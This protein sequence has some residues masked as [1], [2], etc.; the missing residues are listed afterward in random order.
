MAIISPVGIYL[1]KRTSPKAPLPIILIGA[2]SKIEIF[3]LFLRKFSHSLC[4]IS[5]FIFEA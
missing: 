4:N 1:H 3:C 5:C 2:K